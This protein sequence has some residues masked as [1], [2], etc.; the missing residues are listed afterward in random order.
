[1]RKV[2]ILTFTYGD[3]YGQRLQNLAVQKTLSNLG[4][5]PY[6]FK[7]IYPYTFKHK[8][9]VDCMD[10]LKHGLASVHRRN[11]FR[12]FDEQYIKYFSEPIG[13]GRIPQGLDDFH[14]FVAGS[15]QIWS[16]YSDDVNST[17]FL[18]FAPYEK[19]ISY[20]ASIAAESIPEDR[21][22]QYS[23]WWNGFKAISVREKESV[24]L[25]KRISGRDAVQLLDPTLVLSK[26]YW[27]SIAKKPKKRLPDNYI[28]K[29][30]LGSPKYAAKI[31]SFCKKNNYQ[32]VDIMND[33]KFYTMGPC[34][35]LY[36]I[37]KAKA[38]FTDSYHGTI[39]SIIFQVPF[40]VVKRESGK[41]DMSSRFSTLFDS[42]NIQGRTLEDFD[43][44]LDM[45][46]MEI[47]DNITIKAMEN[48]NYLKSSLS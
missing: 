24:D 8:I 28:V 30:F 4:F 37:S 5:H 23:Y 17:M 46:F 10:L 2:G 34:E 11:N 1:M 13:E 47:N 3:N 43:G 35:F 7:Q 45:N 9:K 31:D 14:C 40:I 36:I 25:V 48:V 20:A 19:R 33:N 44:N 15:D 42:L 39:F 41:I 29:Y 32:I 12:K 6:T 22:A 38:I 18:E 16:P 21:I 27:K 26:S